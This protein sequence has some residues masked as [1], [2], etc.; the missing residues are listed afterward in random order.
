M[1]NTEEEAS[2]GY[3]IHAEFEKLCRDKKVSR[4][5]LA[6]RIGCCTYDHCPYRK[7]HKIA[8]ISDDEVNNFLKKHQNL[9]ESL[10]C[11]TNKAPLG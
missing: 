7:D 10:G 2:S 9:R 5:C 8:E 4:A 1:V 6:K 11:C 3:M